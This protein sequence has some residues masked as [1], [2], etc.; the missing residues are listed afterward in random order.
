[1]KTTKKILSVLVELL[2]RT[3]AV[4]TTAAICIGFVWFIQTASG[5]NQFASVVTKVTLVI[6]I[7]SYIPFLIS[8]CKK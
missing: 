6:G 1:M 3:L 4:A 7:L 8:V 2:K 5:L